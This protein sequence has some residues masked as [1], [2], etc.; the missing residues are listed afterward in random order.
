M[1]VRHGVIS[2]GGE[3]LVAETFR[4]AWKEA[5]R[6]GIRCAERGFEDVQRQQMKQEARSTNHII[7]TRHIVNHNILKHQMESATTTVAQLNQST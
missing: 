2:T 5:A 3:F 7:V 1:V 4:N 6:V